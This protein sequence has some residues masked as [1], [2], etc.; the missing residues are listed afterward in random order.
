M[1]PGAPP[2]SAVAGGTGA[3]MSSSFRVPDMTVARN[4][5]VDLSPFPFR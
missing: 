1:N 2:I 5:S 4:G 3:S